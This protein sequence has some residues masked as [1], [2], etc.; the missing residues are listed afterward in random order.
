MTTLDGKA[1]AALRASA[2]AFDR[3]KTKGY[4]WIG[5]QGTFITH[6]STGAFCPPPP[7]HP[8]QLRLA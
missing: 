8:D 2:A 3:A 5:E 4:A 7:I 1:T 6:E